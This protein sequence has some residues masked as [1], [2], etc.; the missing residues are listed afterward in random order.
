LKTHKLGNERHSELR[1]LVHVSRQTVESA[2]H[3]QFESALHDAMSG[4]RTLHAWM[5]PVDVQRH[6]LAASHVSAVGK[7]QFCVHDAE[8]TFHMQLMSAPQGDC[9]VYLTL[10]RRVQVR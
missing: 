8:E 5:Q 6:K 3:T 2:S 1:K 7:L 4:W 10:Q 9:I